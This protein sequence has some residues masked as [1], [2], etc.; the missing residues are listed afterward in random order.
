MKIRY[1]VSLVAACVLLVT[2]SLLSLV[3]VEQL[4]S[5]FRI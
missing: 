4:L 3:Q 2:T 1:K 5:R